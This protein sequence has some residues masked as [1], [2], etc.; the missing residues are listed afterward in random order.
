MWTIEIKV[1]SFDFE[2]IHTVSAVLAQ[3]RQAAPTVQ[4]NIELSIS[5]AGLYTRGQEQATVISNL[6][7]PRTPNLGY[8]WD[9]LGYYLGNLWYIIRFFDE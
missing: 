2:K 4:S 6:T 5:P 7:L 8:Y 1:F 9:N 3:A